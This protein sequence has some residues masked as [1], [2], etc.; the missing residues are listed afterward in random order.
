MS[1]AQLARQGMSALLGRQLG[2]RLFPRHLAQ[3]TDPP[4]LLND[5]V[6]RLRRVRLISE[7]G[8]DWGEMPAR[9]ALE[10]ARAAGRDLM[11]VSATNQGP[12]VVRMVDYAAW[13]AARQKRAYDARKRKKESKKLDRREAV[14][15]QVR[16]SPVIDANDVAIKMRQAKEF[17]MAGYRVRV[18]MQFRKGQGK[19][20]ENAKLALVKA[21]EDLQEFGR[22]QG[23]PKEGSTQDLFRKEQKEEED[24]EVLEGPVKKKPLEVF[25]F[26][27]PRKQREQQCTEIEV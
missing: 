13:H 7:T 1:A 8:E 3:R 25:I 10:R 5:A 11:Q 21:A 14:V 23:I 26:P 9:A 27:M 16:L 19:F 17:L 4:P 18:Y 15:K 12:A 20:E 2:T 24:G 22:I 6:A